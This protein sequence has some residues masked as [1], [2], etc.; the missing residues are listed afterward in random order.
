MGKVI[1]IANQKGGVGKTTTTMNLG[2]GLSK[3]G[4]KVLLIDADSQGNLTICM[5]YEN[6]DQINYTL[7]N[8]L[9]NL[10]L[11]REFDPKEGILH[12]EEGVDF[13]P[14]NIDL[15]GTESTMFEIKLGRESLLN[16]YID[17]IKENYDYI[18][19]DCSPSIGMIT[20]NSLVAADSV[21]IPVDAEYLPYKGLDE[22]TRTIYKTKKK[23]NRK[24]KIEGI[25]LTRVDERTNL[26]RGIIDLIEANYG[27]TMRI[28]QSRIPKSVRVAETSA[29][30]MSIFQ[31]DPEGKATIAYNSL[32][33]E[34]LANE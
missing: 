6:P 34:V 12:S 30:G 5:G 10:M 2:V 18:L 17:M 23:V 21:L 32:T 7:S 33:E 31:Y 22:L 13:V 15:S 26:C 20:I 24:L 11:E 25:L 1:A 16:E 9:G 14:S 19:I 4:K 27:N 3:K 8:I 28:F 29:L